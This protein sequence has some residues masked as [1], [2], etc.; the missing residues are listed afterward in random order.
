MVSLGVNIP[1]PIAPEQRQDRETAAKVALAGK[2]QAALDEAARAATAEFRSL[3][4]DEFRLRQRVNRYL[5]YVLAPAQQRTQA[6]LAG[7]RSSQGGLMPLFEAR[8]AEV[9]AQRKL[10]ALQ[11][12]LAKVQAQLAFKPVAGSTR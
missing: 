1:L 6:A 5:E 12:D 10:L 4:G 2:A 8:H 7:Y 11:R 3:S 9:E